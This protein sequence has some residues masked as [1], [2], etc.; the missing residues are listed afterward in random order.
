MVYVD[1][2]LNGLNVS[3]AIGLNT[4]FMII[5]ILR[6]IQLNVVF[7]KDL[8]RVHHCLLYT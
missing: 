8:Y 1:T 5:N 3:N 7:H 4:L 2:F 6:P